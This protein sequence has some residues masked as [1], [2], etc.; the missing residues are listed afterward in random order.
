VVF[1]LVVARARTRCQQ[2]VG[3]LKCELWAAAAVEQEAAR[4]QGQQ[5]PVEIRLSVPQSSLMGAVQERQAAVLLRAVLLPAVMWL[6][7]AVTVAT[8]LMLVVNPAVTVVLVFSAGMVRGVFIHLLQ[9]P[10]LRRQRIR[11]AAVAALLVVQQL[12][13]VAVVVQEVMA[14][15]QSIP[16]LQLT[17]TPL[18]LVERLERPERVVLL[19]VQ[20]ARA[21]S[22]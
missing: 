15:E 2:D 11:V 18:V 17:L 12:P 14:K 1:L 6:S 9:L 8:A 20:V 19:A 3:A 16:P 4:H 7:L 21:S 22:L 5:E 10:D 13:P